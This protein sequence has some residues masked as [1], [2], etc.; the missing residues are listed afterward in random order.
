MTFMRLMRRSGVA[1]EI[2]VEVDGMVE[3]DLEV[4]IEEDMRREGK[5][6]KLKRNYILKILIEILDF[7]RS[8]SKSRK[9]SWK[10][11]VSTLE[12]IG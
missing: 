5:K 1:T 9:E 10:S 12:T 4:E 8:T 7:W 2:K 3:A 11:K 6:K